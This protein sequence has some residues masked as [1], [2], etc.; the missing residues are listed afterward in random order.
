MNSSSSN[1]HPTAAGQPEALQ[2]LRA[3]LTAWRA[4]RSAYQRVARLND[5]DA[6]H[7]TTFNAAVCRLADAGKHVAELVAASGQSGSL[8]GE[9]D[10]YLLR[11]GDA[12]LAVTVSEGGFAEIAEFSPQMV[13]D[14]DSGD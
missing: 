6:I 14:L 8:P 11:D 10:C 5:L 1:G 4:A 9:N 2:A 12:W 7:I 13:V 3:A